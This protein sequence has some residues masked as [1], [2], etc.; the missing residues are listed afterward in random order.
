[1]AEKL[2]FSLPQKKSKVTAG[3][4]FTIALLLIVAALAVANLLVASRSENAQPATASGGLSAAQVKALA[5]KLAQRNLHEQAAAA[6]QDYLGSAELTDVERANVLFQVA[7]SFEKAG[8]Y[9]DAIENYYRSEATASLDELGPQINAHVKECFEKLGRFASLR[10]EMMDRTSPSSSEPAGGKVVAEIGPEKI[11]EARLDTLIEEAVENELLPMRAYLTLE[12]FNEQK[13]YDLERLRRPQ[14]KGQ[15]LGEWLSQELLYREALEQEL[16]ERPEIKRLMHARTREMLSRRMLEEQLVSKVHITDG[17]VQ[18]YFR[19]NKE[20]YMVPESATI[21]HILVA[22]EDTA[23]DLLAKIRAGADFAA[24]AKEFSLDLTTAQT[25]GRI[26]GEVY[27]GRPMPF[28]GDTK[29]IEAAIFATDAPGVLDRPFET[30]TGWEIVR[31]DEKHP[32]QER[33][34]EEVQQEVRRD[35]RISKG[36]EVQREYIGELMAKYDVV[37]RAAAFAPIPQG[38]S[39]ESSSQQ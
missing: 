25:D 18:T 4:A 22:E 1:M 36:E 3:G 14:A 24:L 30:E 21:S 20:K 23:R 12:Q 9:A 11:T 28:A 37:L 34:F 38:D 5:A 35:L 10:Y 7:T 6:W 15:F 8:R 17:D 39:Q 27:R 2:D 31:V 29:D 26:P 32:P 19:A 13:R 16:G 33:A